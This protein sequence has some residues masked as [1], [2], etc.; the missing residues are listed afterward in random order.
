MAAVNNIR[1]QRVCSRAALS[2]VRI[3]S[4]EVVLRAVDERHWHLVGVAL[5]Q[6]GVAVDINY[7]VSLAGLGTNGSH[8]RYRVVAQ[9]TAL[10][11]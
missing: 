3:H 11:R 5:L 7:G 2:R 9:V 1:A 4:P 8:L 10:P 6:F